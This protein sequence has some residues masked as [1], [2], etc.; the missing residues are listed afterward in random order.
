MLH[1]EV[2]IPLGVKDSFTYLVP[3]A[4]APTVGIGKLVVVPFGKKEW[5]TGVV[6]ALWEADGKNDKIKMITHVVDGEFALSPAYLRF[7]RWVS[8]YYMASLGMVVRAA[9]PV[10][11]R[12]EI[13][14]FN[15]LISTV[16]QIIIQ[17]RAIKSR[18]AET[19]KI[20]AIN[21]FFALLLFSI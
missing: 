3:E 17:N 5:Y 7:L 14:P 11:L 16:C 6:C 12:L 18:T 1:A 15:R 2:I 13:S 20:L 19:V 9:L 10:S 8:E 21:T 4:L